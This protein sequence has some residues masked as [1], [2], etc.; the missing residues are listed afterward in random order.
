MIIT[1][2]I[3]IDEMREMFPCRM[4]LSLTLDECFPYHFQG[5]NKIERIIIAYCLYGM[6]KIG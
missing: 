1:P 3:L 5:F 6:Y 2:I 4:I